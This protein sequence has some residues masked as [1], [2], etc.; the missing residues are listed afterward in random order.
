MIVFTH[1]NYINII[2]LFFISVSV[3]VLLFQV[4]SGM[5]E[6][7]LV[8]SILIFSV[9]FGGIVLLGNIMSG[10]LSSRKQVKVSDYSIAI[11]AV[12]SLI[13]VIVIYMFSHY[14]DLYLAAKFFMISVIMTSMIIFAENYL[15][16]DKINSR[17]FLFAL[18]NGLLVFFSTIFLIP[19]LIFTVYFFKNNF[20]RLA[21]FAVITLFLS[22]AAAIFVNTF[23]LE[24]YLAREPS[25]LNLFLFSHP[26][27]FIF[28]IIVV[29]L[30]AGFLAADLQEVLFISGLMLM[31]PA[32]YGLIDKV[33]A[34]GL[35]NSL[36]ISSTEN[37]FLIF[38][39]PFFIL[40][41]KYYKVDRYLGK[42]ID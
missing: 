34:L 28:L 14:L 1:K 8:I 41:I 2:S 24:N 11:I 40:A 23:S 4:F 36:A 17:F 33:I 12:L 13:S 35:Y 31:A 20:L 16:A 39:V 42:V 32:L 29:G 25:I 27:W 38:P 10:K 5:I 21:L 19:L 6:N 30:F 3:I 9:F 15:A 7:P 37:F 22:I 18:L 26:V